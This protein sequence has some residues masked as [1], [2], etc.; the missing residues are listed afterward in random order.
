M[1]RTITTVLLTLVL[2]AGSINLFAHCEVPCGI[3]D[4]ELRIKLIREHITT[5]EKAMKQI[6]E[7]QSAETVNYNQLVRWINNKESHAVEIQH[8]VEQYFMAQR[9]KPADP[10]EGEKF[11]K[12]ITQLTLLHKLIIFAM[13]SKQTIDLENIT[14]MREVV[15]EFEHSY[16][17]E[18][19]HQH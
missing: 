12:Y 5:I 16:F 9:I 2:I 10:E 3:Y 14:K 19:D 4:D 13:K 11:E 8:I 15:T 17:E 18:H 1:K 6:K 7:I